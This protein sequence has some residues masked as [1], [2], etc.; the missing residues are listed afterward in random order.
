MGHG[1]LREPL[2]RQHQFSADAYEQFDTGCTKCRE[3][4]IPRT[5]RNTQQGVFFHP[6][7]VHFSAT[8]PRTPGR[9]FGP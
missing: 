7:S 3:P 2:Y 6:I 4:P 5:V 8:V 1:F 9:V